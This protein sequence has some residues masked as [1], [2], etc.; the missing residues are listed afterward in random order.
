MASSLSDE[1]QQV[2]AVVGMALQRVYTSHKND[3]QK[4][5]VKEQNMRKTEE[6]IKLRQQKILNGTWHDGRLDCVSGNGV[7]S[8]LGIGDEQWD[9]DAIIDERKES[10]NEKQQAANP[11]TGSDAGKQKAEV[12]VEAISALP[13][14]VIRN[15]DSR[16]IRGMGLTATANSRDSVL[17]TLAQWAG[18]LV[19]NQVAHVI[20]ISDNRENSRRLAKGKYRNDYYWSHS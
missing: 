9:A 3:S 10:Q 7:M 19:E 6:E 8:E 20:V 13:I 1:I 2:L 14:V 11:Q 15:F 4:N 16:A 5:A 12:N 17:N 18:T